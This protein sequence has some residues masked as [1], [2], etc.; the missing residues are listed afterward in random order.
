MADASKAALKVIDKAIRAVERKLPFKSP[1]ARNELPQQDGKFR[2]AVCDD[3]L[4]ICSC[5]WGHHNQPIRGS[6]SDAAVNVDPNT[7]G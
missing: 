7:P 2:C 3:G 1:K 6:Q 5:A 4:R